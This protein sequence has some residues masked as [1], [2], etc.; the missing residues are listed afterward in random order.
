MSWL[1]SNALMKACA[2][3]PSLPVPEAESSADTCL[4]GEQSAPSSGSPTPQAYCAPDKTTAFSRLSRFGMTCAPLTED[5]GEA[6]LMSFL[7]DFPVR[8]LVAPGAEPEL[9]DPPAEC[10]ERW[11]ELFA[12]YD[13][14]SSSWK[15]PQCSLLAGL[16]EFSETWPRWGIMLHGECWEHITPAHL[17]GANESGLW[18]TPSG[19]SGKGH[20]VGRLDEW[21][22]S[23]NPFRGTELASVRSPS[24]EEWMLGWPVSWT[25]LTALETARFQAWR[26]SHSQSCGND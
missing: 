17:T 13:P 19:V 22:G 7:A 18:P 25:A 4:A 20:S 21:G 14:A 5:R 10:G 11:P 6:V 8:T 15:T 1:I 9:T 23:S 24:F 3:L 26:H 16:D 2:N 12:R